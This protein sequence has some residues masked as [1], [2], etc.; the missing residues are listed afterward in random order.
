MWETAISDWWTVSFPSFASKIL[1]FHLV[2]A[3][4]SSCV[5]TFVEDIFD[6]RFLFIHLDFRKIYFSFSSHSLCYLSWSFLFLSR[7]FFPWF[8]IFPWR[9]LFI[10]SVS[11][12]VLCLFSIPGFVLKMTNIL[13]HNSSDCMALLSWKFS[14][15]LWPPYIFSA[16]RNRSQKGTAKFSFLK[17]IHSRISFNCLQK[18]FPKLFALSFLPFMKILFQSSPS[19]FVTLVCLSFYSLCRRR[20]RTQNAERRHRH[21]SHGR[22]QVQA[23]AQDW[24]RSFRRNISRFCLFRSPHPLPLLI[25]GLFC[26][27]TPTPG[28]PQRQEISAYMESLSQP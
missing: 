17:N 14:F 3:L 10:S 26:F 21:G 5:L 12:T 23:P 1:S 9:Y 2:E 6:S 7:Y 16:S 25:H 19:L 8:S 28:F 24:E 13:L 20:R 22:L 4:R 11:F 15:F 18:R 27:F